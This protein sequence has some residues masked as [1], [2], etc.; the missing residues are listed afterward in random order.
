MTQHVEY[1][2]SF[3]DL[4]ATAQRNTTMATDT[5]QHDQR[6]IPRRRQVQRKSKEGSNAFL[7]WAVK[8][9]LVLLI[10]FMLPKLVEGRGRNAKKKRQRR[11]QEVML[12]D[13]RKICEHQVCSQWIPEE[14]MNCVQMCL[15]PACYQD[16]YGSTPIEDG[17]INVDRARDF[18]K[19]V[20]EEMRLARKRQRLSR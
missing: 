10:L 1:T 12:S 7:V 3:V 19:C 15:S 14:S 18:E 6:P 9:L 16:V 17:E 5:P 11:K 20:K 4:G 13:T 8:I 2:A